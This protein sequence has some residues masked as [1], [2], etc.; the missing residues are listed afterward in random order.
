MTQQNDDPDPE[1]KREIDKAA[2]AVKKKLSEMA[3]APEEALFDPGEDPVCT[4]EA[5]ADVVSKANAA[6]KNMGWPPLTP[7]EENDLLLPSTERSYNTE[8]L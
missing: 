1:T 4:K 7:E 2:W 6:R 8:P 5:L 3:Y